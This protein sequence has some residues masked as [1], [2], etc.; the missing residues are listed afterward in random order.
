MRWTE[1]QID[2][3]DRM[4]QLDALTGIC[5]YLKKCKDENAGV[6]LAVMKINELN[7]EAEKIR[8]G[9]TKKQLL[10]ISLIG[11][12]LGG[13]LLGFQRSINLV[14]SLLIVYVILDKK[15]LAKMRVE[16]AEQIYNQNYP[17]L[18]EEK[19][20]AQKKLELLQKSDD[21]YN[22]R[23][24]LPDDFLTLEKVQALIELFKSRRARNI[25]EAMMIC[26]NM[27]HQK[28]M[29]N[30]ERERIKAMQEAA[31]A[32][33]QTAAIAKNTEEEVKKMAAAQKQMAR[34]QEIREQQ[35]IQSSRAAEKTSNKGKK[36]CSYCKEYISKNASVCPYCGR[37]PSFWFYGPF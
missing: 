2:S 18:L 9:I 37:E 14:L 6:N 16:K 11:A 4:E 19:V 15:F 5:N 30:I 17:A 24:F 13:F 10:I 27:E 22:A 29:E 21:A 7:Q 31:E 26:E 23:L 32:Q 25:S 3:F 8:N 36:P 1:Q 12:V 28:R 35:M 34:E 33:R 20:N